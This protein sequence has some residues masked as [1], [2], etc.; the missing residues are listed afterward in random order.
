MLRQ[1][2]P[3]MIDGGRAGPASGRGVVDDRDR[4][5][6]RRG[7]C[8]GP[9]CGTVADLGGE[10]VFEAQRADPTHQTRPLEWLTV[11]A[12]GAS[13]RT[14]W[15]SR[16]AAGRHRRTEAVVEAQPPWP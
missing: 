7:R 15:R 4:S 16:P 1:F 5:E 8:G 9:L 12:S 14:A 10:R 13:V 2:K 3:T 6:R 11:N